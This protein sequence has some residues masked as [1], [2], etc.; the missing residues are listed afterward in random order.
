MS[1]SVCKF[2]IHCRAERSSESPYELLHSDWEL[3]SRDHFA[4]PVS[5][6]VSKWLTTVDMSYV[7][8]YHPNLNLVPKP[9]HTRPTKYTVVQAYDE[10]G[11]E[12]RSYNR[13][14][15]GPMVIALGNRMKQLE[16]KRQKWAAV[17]LPT[18]GPMPMTSLNI[19]SYSRTI[20]LWVKE[21]NATKSQ[22]PKDAEATK[23]N[24]GGI[25]AKWIKS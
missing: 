5:Y 17:R 2:L 14:R 12:Y 6:F 3:R 19:S 16:I 24:D 20:G 11:R 15:Y 23:G 18:M 10:D 8:F 22:N 7:V 9:S 4:H 21:L 25:L 1:R 13:D